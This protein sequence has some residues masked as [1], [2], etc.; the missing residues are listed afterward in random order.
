MRA[1]LAVIL[2]LSVAGAT[3]TACGSGGKS[4]RAPSLVGLDTR[5]NPSRPPPVGVA[6]PIPA[7]APDPP[8]LSA[9]IGLPTGSAGDITFYFS[10][11][12]D[13]YTLREATKG[14]TTPGTGS[15]RHY[16][17]SYA[18]AARTYG[19]KPAVIEAAVKSVEARGLSVM[20]DPS[21]TFVR[22]WA[23]AEQW[24]KVLGQPLRVKTGTPSSPFSVY[25]FP[26]VPKFDK[27][28]LLCQGPSLRDGG[29]R[30]PVAVKG[31]RL[32]GSLRSAL[33]GHP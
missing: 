14:L 7:T 23:T 25:N 1:G 16:F 27:L 19:A 15:Y 5:V 6:A 33:S 3:L 12:I 17:T 4:K 10:L 30:P 32:R 26:S 9:K 24:R 22:V 13:D 31:V 18:E 21:R 2:V 29:A 20:V 11:P 28:K 8:D